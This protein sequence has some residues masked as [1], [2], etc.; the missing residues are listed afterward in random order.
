MLDPAVETAA[1]TLAAKLTAT[2]ALAALARAQ[3][4]L[5]ANEQAE[6]LLAQLQQLQQD[7]L[8]KQQAG[9]LTQEEIDGYRRKQWE[10]QDNAI[11]LAYSEAQRQAQAS[12]PQVNTEI[13]Q[14]L[15]YDF[16]RLATAV[17]L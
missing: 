13:S 3:A 2:P 5:D 11:I 10:V 1:R 4:G 14:A 17:S 12:L 6:S 15:G 16:S 9:T 8:P 7:L